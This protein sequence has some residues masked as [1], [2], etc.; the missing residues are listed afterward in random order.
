MRGGKMRGGKMRARGGEM[1]W[2]TIR[3]ATYI[4]MTTQYGQ[5]VVYS[6]L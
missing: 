6:G 3:M 2:R 5:V 1:R 4:T